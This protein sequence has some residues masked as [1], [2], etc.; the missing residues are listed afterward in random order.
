MSWNPRPSSAI[1]G[2][3]DWGS[4]RLGIAA[5]GLALVGV[6]IG[7]PAACSTDR[8]STAPRTDR[9]D[10]AAGG[11][12][13]AIGASEW[14]RGGRRSVDSNSAMAMAVADTPPPS[15]PPPP[16][17]TGPESV[18]QGSVPPPTERS[19]PSDST[20]S[21]AT[22]SVSVAAGSGR[23]SASDEEVVLDEELVEEIPPQRTRPE[24]PPS[25]TLDRE[26]PPAR[27]AAGTR[28]TAT[29]SGP[30]IASEA[31]APTDPLE[32]A[33]AIL[34]AGVRSPD[35]VIRANALEGMIAWP[36][37][38]REHVAGGLVD[39]N[40]G[41]RFVAAMCIGRA[42]LADLAHLVEPLVRDSSGSVQAAAIYALRRCGRPV[43]PSPLAAMVRS[44]DP[45]IRSNAYI[46]L[47]ELGDRSSTAMVRESLGRGMRRVHPIRV[48]IVELQAAETLVRLGSD[49]ELEVIRAA[50]FAP[51]EQGELSILACQ[52]LARL[53]DRSA[54]PMLERL[55]L[56]S[57]PSARPP[58][59][60]LAA[61]QALADLGTR[62]RID[63][64]AIAADAAEA[65]DPLLRAQ[66]CAV[67][68]TVG[69]TIAADTLARRL[70]D[71]VELVRITAAGNLLKAIAESPVVADA[72]GVR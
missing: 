39:E 13:F 25:A 9:T 71:P 67:A 54:A 63:A 32:A 40:R 19:T 36:S 46:V 47:G 16:P 6:A 49:D 43:D 61:A 56:A 45:E 69:G 52:I 50:L 55:V 42:R 20:T 2:F 62:T 15:P 3:G 58:E 4:R 34:A 53:G 1:F 72:D 26:A 64:A 30:G 7:G 18:G 65:P 37:L 33:A 70:S 21:A 24:A 22:V 31:T 51:V 35:P 10:R 44:D 12:G 23:A 41:V 68:G 38:L 8:A 11:A 17:A 60:R 57:G 27:V 28:E 59:I 5:L 14:S 66:G 29:S 48:R